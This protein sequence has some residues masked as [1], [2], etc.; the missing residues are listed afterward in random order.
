M[1]FIPT[2]LISSVKSLVNY[3]H[4]PDIV[5]NANY[6]QKIL[7]VFFREF[8]N[9]SLFNCIVNYCSLQIKSPTD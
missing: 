8:W 3:A 6:Q 4:I 9:C 7:S 5:H 1:S 2:Y